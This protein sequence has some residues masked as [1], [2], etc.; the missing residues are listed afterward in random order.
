MRPVGVM[1]GNDMT[2]GQQ[3]INTGI[4]TP[5]HLGFEG[6]LN[7]PVDNPRSAC[8]SC[9]ATAQT[10]FASPM[11]PQSGDTA[12]WFR[13]YRGNQ[14]FD[15]GSVPTDYSLQI[16]MGIQNQRLH[17]AAP[18]GAKSPKLAETD[19][20]LLRRSFDSG[21]DLP[22]QVPIQGTLEYRVGR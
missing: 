6:R 17:G 7:G 10:P 2:K 11:M 9:H 8:M 22:V 20:K 12:R 18:A 14:P 19:L 3:W 21:R 15:A 13:N 4:G 5:Q 16:A 1:W